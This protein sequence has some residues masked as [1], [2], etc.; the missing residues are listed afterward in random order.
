MIDQPVAEPAGDLG[1]QRFDLLGLELDHFAG[2]QI[3]QM[4]VMLS[5]ICS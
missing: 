2:A 5:R 3:D 4:V 1:L